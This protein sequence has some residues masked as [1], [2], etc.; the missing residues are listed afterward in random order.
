MQTKASAKGPK[1][2]SEASLNIDDLDIEMKSPN[3][4]RVWVAVLVLWV[5]HF[6]IGLLTYGGKGAYWQLLLN[7]YFFPIALVL[8]AYS[9]LT[10]ISF[11]KE[12]RI[13]SIVFV[14]FSSCRIAVATVREFPSLKNTPFIGPDGV[15]TDFV[16]RT[17]NAGSISSLVAAFC[18]ALVSLSGSRKRLVRQTEILNKTM[19][20]RDVI[21][22]SARSNERYFQAVYDVVPDVIFIKDIEGRYLSANRASEVMFKV[23]RTESI[24]Q[25]DSQIFGDEIGKEVAVM[26]QRVLS[27]ETVEQEF[28]RVVDGVDRVF[29]VIKT[30][31]HGINGDVK[32][33]CGITRDITER[34]QLEEQRNRLQAE[35]MQTQKLESMEMLAG[36][37][38]HDFNNLLTGILGHLNVLLADVPDESSEHE[39]LKEVK[40]AAVSAADLSQQMLLYSGRLRLEV[41]TCDLNKLFK[42]TWDEV[43][44]NAADSLNIVWNL[45]SDLPPIQADSIQIQNVISN[46]ILNSAESMESEAG[47]ITVT[48][49]SLTLKEGDDG[50]SFSQRRIEPGDY[51]VVEVADDGCGMDADSL[52]KVFD[53]FYSSKFIGRGLGMAAVYG[54]VRSHHGF[55]KVESE[56]GVGSVVRMLLPLVQQQVTSTGNAYMSA[57]MGFAKPADKRYLKK[58]WNRLRNKN[59]TSSTKRDVVLMVD[60]EEIVLNATTK[61][62]DRVGYTVLGASSGKKALELLRDR[63]AEISMVLLDLSMPEMSGEQVFAEIRKLNQDI[64]ILLTS[65]YDIRSIGVKF[66]ED[67]LTA[68]LPKPFTPETLIA[69]INQLLHPV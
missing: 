69:E 16:A 20:E 59:K 50:S 57:R 28:Q 4:K 42:T 40:T 64:P 66:A 27:G 48:T 53:P 67:G 45:A 44:E 56:V 54:I 52:G 32:G 5:A 31:L 13:A 11:S 62:L 23:K 9:C 8:V 6:V 68:F 49:R 60:D 3:A 7:D 41:G 30:P 65:G 2:P 47:T 61:V 15:W 22:D 38:A 35:L 24:G 36:G 55:I 10:S 19:R 43:K 37:I 33:I 12:V 17:L 1:S 63:Q 58:R 21:Q 18:L 14:C 29:H 26:D 34:V 39:R 25:N 46:L 51:I